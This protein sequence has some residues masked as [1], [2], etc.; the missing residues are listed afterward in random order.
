MHGHAGGRGTLARSTRRCPPINHSRPPPI[1]ITQATLTH[2]WL[3]L[4]WPLLRLLVYLAIGLLAA[5]F[6]ES[7]NWPAAPATWPG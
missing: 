5:L 4:G 6:I 1:M 7:L 2:L 3:H